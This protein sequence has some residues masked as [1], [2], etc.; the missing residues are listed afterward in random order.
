[1]TTSAP[2]FAC[3]IRSRPS[4]NAYRARWKR[5]PRSSRPVAG[6]ASSQGTPA[7]AS[8]H[9]RRRLAAMTPP[10][11]RF[12]GIDIVCKD[13]PT[14]VEFYREL[15]ID[16]P[17][18]KI[19]SDDYGPQHVDLKLVDD[20]KFGVR[21]DIDSET[22]TTGYYARRGAVRRPRARHR[23]SASASTPV[24]TS[25][26]CTTTWCRSATRRTWPRGTP[27]GR[28]LRHRRRPRR[29]PRVDHG[30]DE[31]RLSPAW[32]CCVEDQ[33]HLDGVP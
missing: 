28:T 8:S 29:Q 31:G 18:D 16:I 23:W 22:M 14:S 25:T 30:T 3:R 5:A 24:K 33:P 6:A 26:R 32:G 10:K 21:F 15:G 17:D 11:A 19:W 9:R 27:S 12:G 7:Y 20:G 4:R 2:M 1:M 13:L